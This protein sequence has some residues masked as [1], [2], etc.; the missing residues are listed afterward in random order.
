MCARIV[1]KGRWVTMNDDQ[2]IVYPY[3][4]NSVPKVKREMLDEGGA[5]SEANYGICP[6][7][8]S[9]P[10]RLRRQAEKSKRCTCTNKSDLVLSKNVILFFQFED[11][12]WKGLEWAN[13]RQVVC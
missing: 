3:I 9:R 10:N 5:K 8:R 7:N 2:A 6:S 1:E 4:P 11:A 12:V 13:L